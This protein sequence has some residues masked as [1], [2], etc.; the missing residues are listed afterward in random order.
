MKTSFNTQF[1]VYFRIFQERYL[2]TAGIL[3]GAVVLI[4]IGFFVFLRPTLAE[5]RDLKNELQSKESIYLMKQ[6]ELS[7]LEKIK[8][9]YMQAQAEVEK[10]AQV[11][12]SDKKIP[13][14]VAQL[15]DITQKAV[16]TSREPLVFKSF[17]VGA[18]TSKSEEKTAAEETAAEETTTTENKNTQ[19][20]SVSYIPLNEGSYQSLPISVNLVGSFGA[21]RY[22]LENLEKNLRLVDIV[23]IS[24][25]G[26][27]TGGNLNFTINL[28]AYFKPATT[29]S[30]SQ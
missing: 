17:S 27:Q 11:L 6:Q 24:I 28:K 15:S 10:A 2:Y 8:Q 29:S 21:L 30:T 25:S 16:A 3:A 4:L 22:Y 12:P 14:L 7:R 5:R 1:K 9:T 13:E 20:Q 26:G 18:A 23:S 19:T